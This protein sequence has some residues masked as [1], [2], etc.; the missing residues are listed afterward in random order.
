MKKINNRKSAFTLIELLVVVAIIGILAA[1]GVPA[2]QSY[3]DAAKKSTVTSNTDTVVKL[4]RNELM[5]ASMG[6]SQTITSATPTTITFSGTNGAN[7]I[8][9]TNI[10]L[11]PYD[12]A[13][14]APVKYGTSALT[15]DGSTGNLQAGQVQIAN[16]G[17][18]ITVTGC[19]LD[20][21]G[22]TYVPLI[23]T[24]IK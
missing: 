14:T 8:S 11:N 10:K 7:F 3:Q 6:S 23:T 1:V 20:T 21:D 18:T 12:S 19:A 4:L 17:A 5:L 9:A 2:Y 24:G 22:T 15:C 16:L 13:D